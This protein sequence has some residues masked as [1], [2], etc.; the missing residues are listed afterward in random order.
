[1]SLQLILA[2]SSP[3]RYSLL[4]RISDEFITAHPEIDE[5]PHAKESATALIKRLA[6]QKAKKI[7]EISPN[8]V[9]IGSD[10]VACLD[11]EPIGKPG[12]F[13][14][15]QAQLK[16]MSGKT[17]PFITGFA[18]V[19]TTTQTLQY[20]YE[21]VNVKFRMLEDDEI[22]RYLNL[23]K[24]FNCCGSFKCE[25]RGIVL[26]DEITCNDPTAIIGLPLIKLAKMLRRENIP[27]I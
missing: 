13:E 9:I 8:A 24:P 2:S 11:D 25:T 15:A 12:N 18:V 27:M 16:R 4:K 20:D 19:N 22:E 6:I 21:T 14:N 7:A 17:I 1:M 26:T 3:A 10:Q 5:I 23:E